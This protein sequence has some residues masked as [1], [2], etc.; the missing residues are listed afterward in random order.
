MFEGDSRGMRNELVVRL[1]PD[2]AIY[3]K[4]VVKKPGASGRAGRGTSLR[5]RSSPSATRSSHAGGSCC[6]VLPLGSSHSMCAALR[7]GWTPSRRSRS[8]TWT[9]SAATRQELPGV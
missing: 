2:E 1:Q 4:M 3:L 8:W 9:T 6:A 7:Q 5:M